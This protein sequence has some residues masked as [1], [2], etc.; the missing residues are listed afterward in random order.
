MENKLKI[1]LAVVIVFLFAFIVHIT[2]ENKVSGKDTQLSEE[3]ATDKGWMAFSEAYMEG[4][5]DNNSPSVEYCSCTLS[6]LRTNYGTQGITDMAYE[7]D[8]TGNLPK[9]MVDAAVE[10]YEVL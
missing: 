6:Y 3:I 8:D 5:L 4:C 7:Y 10:C 2:N 1:A 9:G